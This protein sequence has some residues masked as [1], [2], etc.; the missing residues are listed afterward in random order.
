MSQPRSGQPS[1]RPGTSA[2]FCVL[3]F[4]LSITSGQDILYRGIAVPPGGNHA[5]VAQFDPPV[6]YHTS[7]FGTSWQP[8]YLNTTR[9]VWDVFFLDSLRGWTCG[10]VGAIHGTT[11]GGTTWQRQSLGGPYYATR[12]RFISDLLGW[13]SGGF[14]FVLRTTDGG[15]DWRQI[16]L[17]LSNTDSFDVQDLDFCCPDT[18]WLA[19]GKIADF[20]HTYPGGQGL[21]ARMCNGGDSWTILNRDTVYDFFGIAAFSGSAACVVGGNDRNGRGVVMN[22]SDGGIS[23]QTAT[24]TPEPG[25]LRAVKFTSRTHGWA[26]GDSG[27]VIV[28]DDGG[29]TWTQQPVPTDSD[30]YDI[31]FADANR[32]M[33]SGAGVVLVTTDGGQNWRITTPIGIAEPVVPQRPI[34]PSLRV[35]GSPSAG[36]ARFSVSGISGPYRLAVFDASGRGQTVGPHTDLPLRS[37]VYVAVLSAPGVRLSRRLVIVGQ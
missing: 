17:L 6:V 13:S 31:D 36:R 18:G 1:V 19:V 23:W 9:E 27:T 12:V 11:D 24:V 22:T 35:F 25:L 15:A 5:W 26:C 7:D 16:M 29:L 21:V 14:A 20:R 34:E 28:T 30:L 33:A 4:F 10:E 8:Q 2:V 32:G 3:A 37:G